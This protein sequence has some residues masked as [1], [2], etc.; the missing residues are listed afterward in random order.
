[1]I[2]SQ[3]EQEKNGLAGTSHQKWEVRKKIRKNGMGSD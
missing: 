3:R 1:V 2:A